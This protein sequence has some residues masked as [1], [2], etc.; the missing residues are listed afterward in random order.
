MVVELVVTDDSSHGERGSRLNQWPLFSVST[1]NSWS[2]GWSC[3]CCW[4]L[5]DIFPGLLLPLR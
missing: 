1:L 4:E 5:E 3:C 2:L